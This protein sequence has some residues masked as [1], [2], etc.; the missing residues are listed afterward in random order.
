MDGES[1]ALRETAFRQ[2]PERVIAVQAREHVPRLLAPGHRVGR[3]GAPD[4]LRV[5][6]LV[7]A[8]LTPTTRVVL[9]AR[10]LDERHGAGGREAPDSVAVRV[11]GEVADDVLAPA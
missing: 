3:G 1:E 2:G 5:A 10:H 4:H 6:T 11:T 8:V 9:R 7:D